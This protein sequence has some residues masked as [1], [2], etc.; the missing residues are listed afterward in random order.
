MAAEA[1]TSFA[2]L[3][4]ATTEVAP[5]PLRVLVGVPSHGHCP[6]GFTTSLARAMTYFQSLPYGAEKTIDVFACQG[7]LLPD[8]R[9]RI[10]SKAFEMNATHLIWADSDMLFPPDAFPQ[11]LNHNKPVVGVNYAQKTMEARPTAFV[12]GDEYTGPLWTKD[13]NKGLVEVAHCGFGLMVND[14][15]IFETI[16][17]PYFVFEPAA[18]TNVIQMAEDVYFCRKLRQAGLKIYVDQSLS[19]NIG[20]IGEFV[21]THDMANAAKTIKLKQYRDLPL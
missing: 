18:P 14:M 13:E 19:Q 11:L 1:V 6:I 2:E 15:R 16:D 20:H 21:Y 7:S 12:D 9:T 17:L 8:V 10:V 5:D 3:P 4:D